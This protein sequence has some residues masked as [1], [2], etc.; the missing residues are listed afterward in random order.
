MSKKNKIDKLYAKSLGVICLVFSSVM[1]FQSLQ[2]QPAGGIEKLV[3]WVID[4]PH[5]H[6]TSQILTIGL[7]LV[8]LVFGARA[9]FWNKVCIGEQCPIDTD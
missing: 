1:L 6:S 4:S 7:A 5:Y 9:L 2:G 8:G 3:N